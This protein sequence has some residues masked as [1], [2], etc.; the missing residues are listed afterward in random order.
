MFS[1]FRK[2]YRRL[3]LYPL[4]LLAFCSS[5]SANP[6]STKQPNF[7]LIVADDL[8]FTDIGAFG[9]EI[10]TPNLDA[11]AGSG[12]RLT[13]FH[14]AA[15]CSP[16]RAMLLTGTDH[17]VAGLGNMIEHR[18]PNQVNQPGYEGYLNDRVVSIASLLNDAGYHTYMAGKWHLGMKEGQTP[19]ARGFEESFV[20][21]QGGA[22]HFSDK[23]GLVPQVPYGLYRDNGR[24]V[25]QLPENFYSSNF[26]TDKMIE[27]ID[28]NREDDKP[29]FAYLAF[30]APHWPLQAPDEYI[31]RYRGKY[32]EGYGI[33]RQRRLERAKHYGIVPPVTENSRRASEVVP[34]DELTP[35]QRKIEARKME[36]YAA[37]VE[38]L[39][40]NMGRLL[41]YLKD[42]GNYENTFIMFISDNGAEGADRRKLPGVANWLDDTW[43]QSYSNMGRRNSYVYYG[44]GW[45]QASMTPLKMYKSFVSEG[46]IRSPA[47]FSHPSIKAKGE[48]RDAF[49]S[50]MDIVPTLLELAGIRHP[51]RNYRGKTIHP[52]KGKSLLPYLTKD[53]PSVHGDDHVAGWELFGHRAIRKGNWKLVRLS[54]APP[55]LV[56]PDGADHWQLYDLS[57]DPGEVHNLVHKAPEKVKEMIDLWEQYV[58]QNAL[59]LPEWDKNIAA[60]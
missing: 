50:A 19:D 18:A 45:A 15:T 26:Y 25:D 13:D 27:Y 48:V 10:S 1:T 55:W 35:E 24:L 21:L 41:K 58:S 43:D 44:A 23:R 37:M 3:G 36:I 17:H 49:V 52:L 60:H 39:D 34:W 7:L 12:V 56:T 16:T 59:V 42:S 4:M 5:L 40:Y 11:L 6:A 54:S 14:V 28:G 47:I 9:S 33:L 30:T 57:R 2:F 29:F 31:N 22:S 32:D 38:N 46:G 51:G 8:G 53:L 20:L